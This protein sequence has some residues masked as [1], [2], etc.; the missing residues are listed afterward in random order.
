M[1]PDLYTET[2]EVT[3][4]P[5]TSPIFLLKPELSYLDTVEFKAYRKKYPKDLPLAAPRPVEEVY[6]S[7]APKDLYETP[8]FDI[9]VSG[10]IAQDYSVSLCC[11][12]G[13]KED[14]FLP[15][16]DMNSKPDKAKM[17]E[18][19]HNLKSLNK[20]PSWVAYLLYDSGNSYHIYRNMPLPEDKEVSFYMNALLSCSTKEVCLV[21]FRWLA[22]QVERHSKGGLRIS[23]RDGVFP[24]YLGAF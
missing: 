8:A 10:L 18:F 15:M 5:E 4:L 14:L 9:Q 21:D 20:D 11:K 12:Q 16:L 24:E 23:A 6:V 2:P 1:K 3:W 7:V 22:H 19:I 17:V 13:R